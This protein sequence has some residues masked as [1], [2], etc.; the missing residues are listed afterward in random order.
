MKMKD[1]ICPFCNRPVTDV[2][3]RLGDHSHPEKT[4][5][6]GIEKIRRAI[7]SSPGPI[8][9]DLREVCLYLLAMIDERD[10]MIKDENIPRTYRT[11]PNTSSPVYCIWGTS[12]NTYAD[13]LEKLL[14]SKP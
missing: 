9:A 1:V 12:S 14:K 5:H 4:Q 7:A 6:D 10:A 2:P 11:L 3:C 8:Y 13:E